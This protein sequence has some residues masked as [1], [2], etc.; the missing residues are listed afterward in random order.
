[1]GPGSA[2]GWALSGELQV[3]ARGGRARSGRAVTSPD[4]VARSSRLVA[5]ILT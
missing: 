3:T 2:E 1:M 5:F 4:L